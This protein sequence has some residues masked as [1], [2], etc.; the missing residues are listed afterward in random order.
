[1]LAV[2]ALAEQPTATAYKATEPLV[3][4]GNLD[5]WNTSSPLEINREDQVIRDVSFWQGGKRPERHGLCDVG[6]GKPLP[7]RRREGRYALR[8]H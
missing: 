2:P 3:I 5:D 6:R 8:R 4:D 7:G 1:M